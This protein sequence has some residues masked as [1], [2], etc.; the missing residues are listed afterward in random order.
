MARMQRF[1]VEFEQLAFRG[2]FQVLE[3]RPD[4]RI[5][6]AQ[7]M[8]EEVERSAQREGIEPQANLRQFDGHRVQID[9]VDAAL[10]N[11]PFEQVDVG[12]LGRVN[13]D[14]LFA[15]RFKNALAGPVQGEVDRVDRETGSG[16]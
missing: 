6:A 12:Q 9:S 13:R 2:L 8:V 14:A 7:V 4:E 1:V 15:Q 5:A 3:R 16:T 11:V 10:E